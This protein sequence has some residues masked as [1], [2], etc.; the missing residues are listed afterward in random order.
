MFHGAFEWEQQWFPGTRSRNRRFG[1]QSQPPAQYIPYPRRGNS[2]STVRLEQ[3]FGG[4]LKL[5]EPLC[6]KQTA[7]ECVHSNE[8]GEDGASCKD[9]N[10]TA[11]NVVAA[12]LGWKLGGKAGFCQR[13]LIFRCS[14]QARLT[15]ADS[16]ILTLQSFQGLDCHPV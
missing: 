4:S 16:W 14:L 11:K 8:T 10:D 2:G 13:R 7:E 1:F 9:N 15:L 12:A 3:K 6:H 5:G